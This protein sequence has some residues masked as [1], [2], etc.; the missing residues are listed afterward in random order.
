M[1]A[2]EGHIVN[3][4]SING[5]F[6]SIGPTIPHTAYSAAKFAVRGFSEALITDL[7]INA[8]TRQGL[9]V[10]PGHV[11]TSIVIQLGIVH[12]KEPDDLNE[13][14]LVKIRR[15]LFQGGMP[16]DDVADEDLRKGVAMFGEAFRDL[17]PL[18]GGVRGHDHPRRRFEESVADPRRATTPWSSTRWSLD[19]G[20]GVRAGVLAVTAGPGTLPRFR[21]LR[22]EHLTS[23]A[24]TFEIEEGC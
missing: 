8:P 15:Q 19:A 21:R 24:E 14:D 11:G 13:E 3:T 12:G 22:R 17:A 9:V 2:T 1:E 4:S 18:S 6:A 10:M 20:V 7:R 5:I 16:V 23:S